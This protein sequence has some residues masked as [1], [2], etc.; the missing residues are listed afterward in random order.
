MLTG[1]TYPLMAVCGLVMLMGCKSE[2]MQR[3]DPASTHGCSA[4]L[5][6]EPDQLCV[7][8]LCNATCATI[9]DCKNGASCL[10]TGRGFACLRLQDNACVTTSNC[11]ARTRCVAGRCLTDCESGS[12]TQ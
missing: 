6:C 4:D 12:G 9:A 2:P 8:G 3:S 5:D 10:D 1:L 11:P 7:F